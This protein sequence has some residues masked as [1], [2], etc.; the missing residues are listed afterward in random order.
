MVCSFISIIKKNYLFYSKK[1]W[2]LFTWNYP[3]ES[4]NFFL[5]FSV[6]FHFFANK[7]MLLHYKLNPLYPKMLFVPSLIEI[8]PAILEKK[9]AGLSLKDRQRTTIDHNSSFEI[10][11]QVSLN[12]V[13]PREILKII[14]SSKIDQ[15]YFKLNY[16]DKVQCFF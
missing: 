1:I 8:N 2:I 5:M 12:D 14:L 16:T 10:S 6:H 11:A 3:F 9:C 13:S 15:N 7:D 4:G